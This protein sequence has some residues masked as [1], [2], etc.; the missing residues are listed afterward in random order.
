M[1]NAHESESALAYDEFPDTIFMCWPPRRAPKSDT[2]SM[3]PERASP[4]RIVRGHVLRQRI[5]EAHRV[6]CDNT[7]DTKHRQMTH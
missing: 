5:V 3:R 4:P 2:K 6:S 7:H 1:G